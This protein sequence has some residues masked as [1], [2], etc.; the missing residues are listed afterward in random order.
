MSFDFIPLL[1][2]DRNTL[3]LEITQDGEPIGF[4]DT[5]ADGV[6]SM[7]QNL[8]KI[9]ARMADEF[10]RALEPGNSVL[11]DTTINPNMVTGNE[12]PLSKRALMTI[13]HP[14]YG[15]MAYAMSEDHARRLTFALTVEVQRMRSNGLAIPKKPGLIIPGGKP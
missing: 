2:K 9:R 14:G 15:W 10:P 4:I 8:A 12:G 13:R 11:P 3:R 6:T 5:D 7:I 1:S